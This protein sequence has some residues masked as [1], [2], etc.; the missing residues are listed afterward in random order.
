MYRA[1]WWLV[2]IPYLLIAV[3]LVPR[4][5]VGLRERLGWIPGEKLGRLRGGR[6]IWVHA[7]SVGEAMAAL[8]L[9]RALRREPGE[10]RI[11]MSTV[12]ETGNRAVR[13]RADADLLFFAPIDLPGAVRRAIARIRPVAYVCLETELWPHLFRELGRRRIPVVIVNGRLSE[14]TVR[15]LRLFRGLWRPVLRHVTFFGVQGEWEASVLKDLG[16]PADRIYRTGNMKFDE[17]ATTVSPE[18]NQGELDRLKGELGLRDEPV[19]VAGSTHEGEETVLLEVFARLRDTFPNL[20]LILAPRRLER[21]ERLEIEI[22]EHGLD[23]ALRSK[24]PRSSGAPPPAV[25][26]VDRVGELRALYG[27]G[28]FGFV[29]GSLVPRGGHNLLEPAAWGRPV[30]FGPDVRNFATIAAVLRE[31]RGG[32]EVNG[33]A[34]LERVARSLL[35]DPVRTDA[36]GQRARQT[37]RTYQGAAER[38]LALI[39]RALE[40]AR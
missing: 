10:L 27:L 34:A 26:L 14:R 18:Q 15:R 13:D 33:A 8:P 24:L 1:L 25:I 22:R 6:V 7:V 19:W 39:R 30:L 11:A 35:S 20:V 5:R 29:G 37:I 36:L 12:T 9:L 28:A 3:L 21:I 40:Q 2:G 16:V 31:S 4:Y 23:V 38:N 32:I 17:A